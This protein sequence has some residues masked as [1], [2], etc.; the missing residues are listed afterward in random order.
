[1]PADALSGYAVLVTRPAESSK[2]LI[3]L[4]NAE[5]G[6]AIE[7]P[8][9]KIV[10]MAGNDSMR[11]A[12]SDLG[13]LD[14]AVF[15]SVH[16]ARSFAAAIDQHGAHTPGGLKIAA[17]G[18]TTASE[19]DSRGY[20]VD[21]LPEKA[22]SSEGLIEKLARQDLSGQSAVIFRG[23]SGRK[24]LSQYLRD[25]GAIVTEVESYRRLPNPESLDTVLSAWLDRPNKLLTVTSVEIMQRF[26]EKVPVKSRGLV[27]DSDV[28]VLSER[29]ATACEEAGFSARIRVAD[30][31]D[32]RGLVRA[33][34]ACT[35]SPQ[36]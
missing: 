26:I 28:A 18:P 2:N 4:I 5:G 34:V 13:N 11:A 8:V 6:T 9:I 29:I 36:N 12:I 21:Y 7:F 30:T 25:A 15:V 23:Q 24:R 31:S 20:S 10:S 33:L 1:M 16:A 14:L 35:I 22:A 27:F 3:E 19:L 32:D 17:V